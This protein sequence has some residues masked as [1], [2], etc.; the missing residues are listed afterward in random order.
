MA[1]EYIDALS[2]SM[3]KSNRSRSAKDEEEISE[4]I[5][6]NSRGGDNPTE[7]INKL[8]ETN[9]DLRLELE[10]VKNEKEE[11]LKEFQ[12]KESEWNSQK[13]EL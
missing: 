12:M 11:M 2:N 5:E 4:E 6:N 10:Q 8:E 9:D 7:Q 1:E 13:V 3:K